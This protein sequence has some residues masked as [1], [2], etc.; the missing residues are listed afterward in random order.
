[1]TLLKGS[2]SADVPASLDHC[3]AVVADI[4]RAPE[5]QRT[6]A[7]VEVLRRD[8]E[9]RA[10]I[11]DT[12]NDAKLKKIRC[13]VRIGYEPPARLAFELVQS[14]DLD[15]MEGGWQLES[16]G[17]ERTRAIYTL[18]VDPGPIGILARPLERAIRPLVMGHQADEL[19]AVLAASR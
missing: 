16:L 5:W 14:H 19:A 6:L 13:R 15:A 7:A 2:C 10:L 18:A 9:G 3:W 12:I 1:M 4:E 8:G 17:P 11:C